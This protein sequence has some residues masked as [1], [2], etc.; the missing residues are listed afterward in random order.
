M[1]K[2]TDQMQFWNSSFGEEYTKRNPQ[3]FE[4]SDAFYQET[5]GIRRSLLNQEF[6]GSLDRNIKI[7]E[8][9]ANICNQLVGLQKM[10]FQN[11][12]GIELQAGAVNQARQKTQ[13]INIIQGS[14][15]DLPF[16]D[17]YFDLVYTSG[18]LI[19]LAPTDLAV[20]IKE[21]IRCSSRYIW[22]WEYFAET[23]QS[24]KYRGY[25][26]VLWK[27][28]F[29]QK[30][31]EVNSRLKLIKEKKVKYLNDNNVDQMFL[32]EKI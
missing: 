21:I 30:Y 5:F 32:I 12:Y 25:E 6:L 28:N 4:E 19:H 11:L 2:P 16:K 9:G 1:N 8:V 13:N 29:P 7:L 24:V 31:T 15:F 20:A 3:S 17:S 10:G 27:T 26:N 22:G 14:A 18:V 23:T